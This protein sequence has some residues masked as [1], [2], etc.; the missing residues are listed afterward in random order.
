MVKKFLMLAIMIWSVSFYYIQA[1]A[2]ADLEHLDAISD[3]ALELA[4]MKKF[5]ESARMLEYFST[6]FLEVSNQNLLFSID[7]LRI[8]TVAHNDALKTVKA[9]DT[10]DIEKIHSVTKFRLA[11]DAVKS[12]H[13]PL[14]TALEDQMMT[15]F[16]QTQ[17]AVSQQNSEQFNSFLNK[18]LAQYEMIYPSLKVDLTPAV[19]EKLDAR[20]QYID[21]YR[22]GLLADQTGQKELAALENDL[23]TIF[24]G[25]SEDEAD[26]SLW[27]VI[28]TTG[29]II[30]LTLSYVGWRK[31]RGG[32]DKELKRK[33]HND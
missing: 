4:E 16:S 10:S 17:E 19:I 18:L 11:M 6:S 21:E 14:W 20:V 26:P 33:D 5:E 32:T 29:S 13:Q 12:T 7:E 28:L 24:E 1:S 25:M 23:K 15:A 27:W 3:E 8:M 2:S 31:Y 22:P 9:N 30:I